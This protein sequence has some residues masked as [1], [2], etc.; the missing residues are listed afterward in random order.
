[1]T[2]P[3]ADFW[4]YRPVAITG[5]TG[6]LGSHLTAALVELGANVV[7]VVRDDVVP[8][9]VSQAWAGKIAT[10][11]GDVQD[12]NLLERMLGEYESTVVFH[13]AA[14]SQ[15]GVSNRNPVST[16]ESNIGG[17]WSLLEAVRHSPGVA[18]VV[19]ASSDKAYGEQPTLP[20]DE[21]MPLSAKHPYDVS[22]ACADMIATSYHHTFGVP[23]C[24][25]RCGNFF[26]PGDTNWN[27]L[28]P[29]TARS[30][31]R[32]E[33][34]IIRSDGTWT[35]DYLHVVDGALAYMRTAEAMV[36]DPKLIGTAYNFSTE[37]PASVLE[38]VELM[39]AEIGVDLEPDVRAEATNEIPH[40]YLSA[41][42]ARQQ[43]GWKPKFTLREG[44][45]DTITWYR[46]FLGLA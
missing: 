26:G 13:L 11:R 17:T 23:V 8:T 20:Y 3:N 27:R 25:T 16:W 18:A 36:A 46:D 42:R 39:R 35:R 31:L 21:D 6:F 34:P 24:I 30:L 37:T 7:A 10:V 14:Q 45:A 22:K 29:G 15:I 38:L 28:V 43:L 44:L 40:Q 5:A 9:P 33:R 41:E 1:M 4:R 32:G 12:Q 2:D 19:V